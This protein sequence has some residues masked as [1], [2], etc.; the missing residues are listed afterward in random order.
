M[1]YK[2]IISYIEEQRKDAHRAYMLSD[3]T[4]ERNFYYV[5]EIV[6]ANLLGE[7]KLIKAKGDKN[8]NASS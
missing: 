5:Q 8:E 3:S 2:E 1:T 4:K 7:L 6:L